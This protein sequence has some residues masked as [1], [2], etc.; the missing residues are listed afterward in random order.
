MYYLYRSQ[1]PPTPT[2]LFSQNGSRTIPSW[3]L[4]ETSSN[5]AI[6]V[7]YKE[8]QNPEEVISMDGGTNNGSDSSLE[9]I[10]E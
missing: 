9:M 7:K 2:A 10:K 5:E 3:Q 6:N 1:F 4:N 8:E